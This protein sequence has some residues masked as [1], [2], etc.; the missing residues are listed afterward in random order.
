[1]DIYAK[2]GGAVKELYTGHNRTGVGA[3]YLTIWERCL[4]KLVDFGPDKVVDDRRSDGAILSRDGDP[5][6]DTNM[7]WCG[8][9]IDGKQKVAYYTGQYDG[10]PFRRIEIDN[11]GAS[12]LVESNMYYDYKKVARLSNIYFR[13]A[14]LVGHDFL[15]KL[16]SNNYDQKLE[17]GRYKYA[18]TNKFFPEDLEYDVKV[19]KGQTTVTFTPVAM[20]NRIQLLSVNG[21]IHSSRCPITVKTNAPAKITVVGPDGTETLTYTLTFVEA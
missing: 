15:Y 16:G 8:F 12:K 21:E 14:E 6:D 3:D 11:T 10:K 4:Q 5:Y 17:D 13:D 19:K 18:L 2:D 1:M 20:S 7:N 9:T